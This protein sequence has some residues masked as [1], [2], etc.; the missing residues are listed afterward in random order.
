MGSAEVPAAAA[1]KRSNV[2]DD[3]DESSPSSKKPKYADFTTKKSDDNSLMSAEDEE[4]WEAENALMMQMAAQTFAEE[5]K[6]AANMSDVAVEGNVDFEGNEN[7]GNSDAPP[8]T[9]RTFKWVRHSATDKKTTVPVLKDILK[10]LSLGTSGNRRVLFDRIRDCSNT[11]LINKVD[12]DTFEMKVYDDVEATLPQWIILS[13]EPVPGVDGIDMETGATEGFYAPTNPDNVKMA[14]NRRNF[15]TQPGE[16]IKRPQFAAKPKKPT[17]RRTVQEPPSIPPVP[18]P[19]PPEKGGPS[20][21]ARKLIGDIRYVRPRDIF[22]TQITDDFIKQQMVGS[23]NARAVAEGQG[24]NTNFVPF[25]QEEIE[26]FIGF[27]FANGITPRPQLEEWFSNC[28]LRGNPTMEKLLEKNLPNGKKISAKD[29]LRQFRRFM[30]L[31]DCRQNVR[32]ETKKDPLYKVRP[33]LNELN[34]QAQKMWTTGKWVSID[35]QTIGFKGRSGMKLRISYKREGDGFQCDA[36]CEDGYTFSF[37]FRHGDAPDVGHKDLALSPTARRVVWLV[38]RLSNDWTNVFMDNLFNSRKLF[39]ALFREKS[40][41]HGVTRTNGRGVCAEVIQP[42]EKDVKK[43]DRLRGTTKAA[44]LINCPECPDLIATS[45]YDTKPVH[46]LSMVADKVEWGVKERH[47]VWSI[48]E[49]ELKSMKFLRLNVISIY[50]DFMN[51]V[52]MS[53]QLRNNYRPDHWMRQ[54]KWWWSF[55]LWGIGVACTNA[56]KIYEVLY[57]EE[58]EKLKRNKKRNDLPTKWTHAEFIIELINDL[59]WPE[60]SKELVEKRKAAAASG[61]SVRSKSTL[62]SGKSF[63]SSSTT[64][65]S[66]Q[67]EVESYLKNNTPDSITDKRLK[68]DHFSARHDGKRHASIPLFN[69]D[70]RCQ[71]CYYKWKNMDE[72]AKKDA[73]YMRQNRQ[74]VRRCLV[75]HVNLCWLCENDWHGVDI[76]AYSV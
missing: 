20:E 1:S 56:W 36:L 26:R 17:S 73:T 11:D 28:W 39:T 61:S 31:Y 75:C 30:C 54:R 38:Q 5:E 71:Y 52:D 29:R 23:T 69:S 43:A 76:S 62:K 2:P 57:D 3:V 8:P 74:N 66:S 44:R 35:E 19:P 9:E 14:D 15:L 10:N 51:S 53:D 42:V 47:R 46:I 63:S 25:D 7:V 6:A 33:L 49:R 45:V 12:A 72:D 34:Y 24:A 32:E 48:T 21:E 22:K 4:K 59:M 67:E 37:Y 50:N 16:A 64:D 60:K 68:N 13:G 70:V 41:G 40:K 55:F 27:F 65:L 58:A 18:P